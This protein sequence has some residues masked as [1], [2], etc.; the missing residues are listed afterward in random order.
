MER[1]VVKVFGI[2]LLIFIAI[3]AGGQSVLQ[4]WN[5]LVPNLF[6]LKPITFWQAVGLLALCRLL[7]GGF[8]LAGG[9]RRRSEWGHRMRERFGHMTPEQRDA[10]F[11]STFGVEPNP[12]TP[13]AK[14]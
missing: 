2:L 11:R 4:L 8:G 13:Q 14:S 5:W 3:V 1:R 10:F 12:G 7:F 6:G 9:P